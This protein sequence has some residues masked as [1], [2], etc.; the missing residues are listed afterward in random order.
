MSSTNRLKGHFSLKCCI[1]KRIATHCNLF[2]R[3][4]SLKCCISKRIATQCNLFEWTLLLKCDTKKL[5]SFKIFSIKLSLKILFFRQNTLF[6]VRW[7]FSR[8]LKIFTPA[9]N[10]H[11]EWKFSEMPECP[12]RQR[13]YRFTRFKK[14]HA[15]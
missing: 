4:H 5:M 2:E 12:Y 13:K 15:V 6:H 3:I 11:T 7:K 8:S 1:S 10:F 9:E 14:F